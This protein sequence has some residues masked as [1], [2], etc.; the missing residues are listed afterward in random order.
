MK[1]YLK[2]L[3]HV[4]YCKE[5]FKIVLPK[6][7]FSNFELRTIGMILTA[8]KTKIAKSYASCMIWYVYCHR[9]LSDKH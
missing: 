5:L 4:K 3:T 9:P 1:E 7:R 6:V 2:V 8:I